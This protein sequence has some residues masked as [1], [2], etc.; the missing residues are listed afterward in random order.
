MSAHRKDRSINFFSYKGALL[1][2]FW[3]SNPLSLFMLLS[4]F[5]NQPL[6]RFNLNMPIYIIISNFL[7]FYSIYVVNIKIIPLKKRPAIK[8]VFSIFGTIT[9][10]FFLSLT[11]SKLLF[12]FDTMSQTMLENNIMKNLIKDLIIVVVAHIS[13]MFIYI[14]NKE[15]EA[16][17]DREK[18]I[19]ENIRSRYEVLKSQIDPHFIFNSLNTLDGLIGINDDGAHAYLQSFSSVFRYVVG[20]KEITQLSDELA[21]T[22]SYASMM[23]VRYGDSFRIEYSIDEKYKAW[24]VMP[25][26]LQLLVENAVKHNVISSKSPLLIVIETTPNDTIRVKNVINLKKE[27]ERGESIGL[28]NLIDRYKLMFRK[29][30]LITQTDMFC[31]EIPLINEQE[32]NNL[33]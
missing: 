30:V 28:A 27:P 26:S 12:L 13:T 33:K 14:T 20:N 11:F 17:V 2:A 22:E 21:F 32:F 31:V 4:Y 10:A 9:I 15:K 6:D 5:Y 18:F 8:Y 7:L 24:F 1:L 29:D 25:I 3:V 23:K 19:A 16:A